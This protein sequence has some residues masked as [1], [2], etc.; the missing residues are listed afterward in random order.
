MRV[1]SASD[2]GAEFEFLVRRLLAANQVSFLAK[3]WQINAAPA[4]RYPSALV[5]P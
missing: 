5:L 2:T 3:L 4:L 1:A